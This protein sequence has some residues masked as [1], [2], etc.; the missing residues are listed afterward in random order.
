MQ[1]NSNPTHRRGIEMMCQACNQRQAL[2]HLG[3]D[4][5]EQHFCRECA[6]EYYART[7]GMN[8]SRHL[9]CLSDWYRSKLYDLLE[10]THPE[11]FDNHDRDACVRGSDIMRKFLRKQLRKANLQIS[12]DAFQ[13]LCIDFYCSHHFYRRADEFKKKG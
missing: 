5:Q 3:L 11:A 4:F 8:S 6:D 10:A 13:M 2:V 9:I 7:P 1:K 12:G